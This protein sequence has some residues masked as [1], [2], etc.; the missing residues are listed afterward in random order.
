MLLPDLLFVAQEKIPHPGSRKEHRSQCGLDPSPA[1][2]RYSAQD[3]QDGRGLGSAGDLELVRIFWP[4]YLCDDCEELT[5]DYLQEAEL[6]QR[7]HLTGDQS[8]YLREGLRLITSRLG[9]TINCERL[10]SEP[11]V[12]MIDPVACGL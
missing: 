2:V 3:D 8:W 12:S 7:Q 9:A 4:L 1:K 10:D 5:L 6:I 11:I